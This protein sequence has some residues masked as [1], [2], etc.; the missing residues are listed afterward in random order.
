MDALIQE[1]LEA[2]DHPSNPYLVALADGSLNLE[3]FTETQIQFYYAVVFFNR[4]MA[5]CAAKIPS[6]KLRREILRN[7]WEEHGEGEDEEAHGETFLAFLAGLAGLTQKEVLSRTLWPEVRMFNTTLTGACIVDEY[8]I[9]VGVLG[10]IERMFA[11]IAA[12]IGNSVVQRGWFSPDELIHYKVHAEID[13]R[14]AQDFFDVLRPSWEKNDADRY[15]IEQ[16]LRLG[17]H[18]FDQLY[19]GLW[20]ARTRRWTRPYRVLNVRT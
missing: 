8:L 15:Y 20:H 7:V 9:G 17:A 1:I 12:R 2:T 4:P 3:D 10:M 11:D 16:G 5:A 19:R 14:H 13:I 6:T 18:C